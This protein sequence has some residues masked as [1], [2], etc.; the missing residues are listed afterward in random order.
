MKEFVDRLNPHVGRGQH[1][2]PKRGDEPIF[3]ILVYPIN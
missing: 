1:H 2:Y 3:V